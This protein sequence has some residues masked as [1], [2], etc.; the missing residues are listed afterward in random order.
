V[1]RFWVT[2]LLVASAGV[3]L[4]GASL[5][6]APALGRRAFSLLFYRSPGAMDAFGP[7]AARYVAFAHAVLGAVLV[8]WGTVM[9]L[10]TRD[11]LAR[12]RRAGWRLLAVSLCA[13]FVP[14]TA[15]SLL[16]GFW[17]NALLNAGL[18]VLFVLPL[19]AT[20]RHVRKA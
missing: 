12:G 20:R 7:E 18:L 1:P 13:W 17:P 3:V 9:F 14:D 11:L 5:V 8:G 19:A 2:W 16:S 10:V 4:L 15:Y 6:V